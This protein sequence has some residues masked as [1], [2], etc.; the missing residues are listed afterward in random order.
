MNR[1]FLS[2]GLLFW[3]WSLMASVNIL[4][5]QHEAREDYMTIDVEYKGGCE[6]HQFELQLLNSSSDAEGSNYTFFLDHVLGSEDPCLDSITQ[7]LY[8]P[9]NAVVERPATVNISAKSDGSAAVSFAIT[10]F[11]KTFIEHV[12]YDQESR[13]LVVDIGYSGGCLHHEF[14][15]EYGPCM[16]TWP[17]QCEAW[18]SHTKGIDDMC[19]A[20]VF[21]QRN[22]D[23]PSELIPSL[24][25]LTDDEGNSFQVHVPTDAKLGVHV[26]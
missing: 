13:Q 18:I 5:V 25:F 9:A 20:Y 26:N 6:D 7:T 14:I 8:F 16:A 11:P 24:L 12:R 4:S 23:V 15:L 3:S 2:A 21:E 22:F 10:R 17:A 1:I 19:L